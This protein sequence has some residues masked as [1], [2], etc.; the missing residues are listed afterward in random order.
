MDE[1]FFYGDYHT[2]SRYSD[3]SSEVGAIA[4]E[5][6]KKGLKEVAVT[7][8]GPNLVFSG[9]RNLGAYRR[10]KEEIKSI[11][12]LAVKVLV[13]GE[14][15]IISIDGDLDI[16]REVYEEFDVLICGLHPYC[17]PESLKDGLDLFG[18]NHLAR[19]SA[20]CRKKAV[21]ANTRAIVE[22][23]AKHPIDILAHPGLFFEVDIE[24]V[25]L[26]CVA[27][28]VKF[29]INCG[30]SFPRVEDVA[31]ANKIGV[32]FIVSSDAH[33]AASVGELSYGYEILSKLKVPPE[34]VCNLRGEGEGTWRGKRRE[35]K[36]MG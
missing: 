2:H 20:E 33:R 25:A 27:N 9:V 18:T 30:H 28:N 24:E 14:A 31:L 11:Q 4:L 19:L 22:A 36:G 21:S 1:S 12:G 5:A 8:H 26:A 6:A 15:N 35:R 29:E 10:V 32:E 17:R 16:P 3:G 34:R 7:D 23:L 13:G